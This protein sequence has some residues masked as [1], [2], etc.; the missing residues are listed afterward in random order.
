VRPISRGEITPLINGRDSNGP[1]PDVDLTEPLDH[2]Q[3][4]VESLGSGDFVYL[5]AWFFEPATELTRGAYAATGATTWGGLFAAKATE[6]VTIRILI[7]DFDPISGLDKWLAR[8]CLTPLDA[9]I[10]G[11]P[12]AAQDNLKYVVS[13]HPAHLGT[14]KSLLA[15]QG[16][17]SIYIASHHEKFMVANRGDEMFAFCGGLDIESRKTPAVWSYGGLSGWHDIHVRLEGPVTR[18]LEREFVMRWNRERG[19]STRAALP[20]WS[21]LEELKLT[22]LSATDDTSAKKVHQVQMLRTVSDDAITSPYDTLRDDIAQAYERGI[23][24]ASSFVYIEN[25]YFRS[26]EFAGWLVAAGK[27]NPNL[28]VIIVVVANAAA[29]DGTNALTEH[30]DYLQYDA[31]KAVVDGLGA[32]RVRI[33]TM[34]DRA[35]HAKFITCDDNWMCIGSANGNQRSFALDTELNIQT[36]EGSLISTFRTRLWSHNLGVDEAT[37]AGW[38]ASDFLA[39]WDAVAAANAGL[40]PS[41]MAGEGII[42]FD[43]T[44]NQGKEHSSVPPEYVLL[45]DG[46]EGPMFA[47]ERTDSDVAPA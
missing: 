34:R 19:N 25:Q 38:S 41:E 39:K 28:V 47:G 8:D 35:V 32:S 30:G 4:I 16:G 3:F 42:A 27:A 11:L 15:G 24:C 45:D 10:A 13:L 31:F 1:N 23:S 43:Y 9:I 40:A 33:Y 37:I 17:R 5:S 21:A 6:G 7:N 2:M 26:P 44:A 14:L 46:P 29:D 20:G 22:P 12:A 18:D 36:T